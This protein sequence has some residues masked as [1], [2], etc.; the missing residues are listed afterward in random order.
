[1]VNMRIANFVT[2]KTISSINHRVICL[3]KSNIKEIYQTMEETK[4]EATLLWISLQC[5]CQ[6][7]TLTMGSQDGTMKISGDNYS[8]V[9]MI[10]WVNTN[11]VPLS[12]LEQE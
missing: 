2:G 5:R 4:V 1:M 8:H 12:L 6:D 9:H 11:M 10:L 3:V 7:Y